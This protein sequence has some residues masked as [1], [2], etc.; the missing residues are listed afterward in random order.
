MGVPRLCKPLKYYNPS[1]QRRYN[2]LIIITFPNITL[3]KRCVKCQ[4]VLSLAAFT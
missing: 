4:I 2:T 1:Q 3:D